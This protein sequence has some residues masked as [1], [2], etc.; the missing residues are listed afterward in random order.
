M[1]EQETNTTTACGCMYEVWQLPNIR[2]LEFNYIY[3]R[4]SDSTDA[5]G[6]SKLSHVSK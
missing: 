6:V 4:D 1:I 3:T 5:A 2:K